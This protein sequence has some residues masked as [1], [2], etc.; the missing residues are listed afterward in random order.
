MSAKTWTIADQI[1]FAGASGDYNPIHIDP[2]YARRALFG[3]VVVHGIHL[4]VWALDAYCA[5][6][7][8]TLRLSKLKVVFRKPL[9]IN[10]EAGLQVHEAAGRTKLSVC[11]QGTVLADIVIESSAAGPLDIAPAAFLGRYP[12]CAP[13]EAA[14][15]GAVLPGGEFEI[16]ADL[17]VA[18]RLFPHLSRAGTAEQ[19]AFLLSTTRLVGMRCPGLYSVYNELDV[20]FAFSAQQEASAH[21]DVVDFNDVFKLALIQVRSKVAS[22]AIKAFV[23][24]QYRACHP[25]KDL[26]RQITVGEFARQKALVVGGSRGLGALTAKILALGGADVSLT[27]AKSRQDAEDLRQEMAAEGCRINIAE[28]DVLD[29]EKSLKD[30]LPADW[31]PTHL[32]YFAT[33]FVFEGTKKH[34]SAELFERFC[35]YYVSGFWRISVAALSIKT[36]TCIVY[37]SSSALDTLPP[38]MLEYVAAKQAGEAM[39]L[40]IEK[41][42]PGVKVLS[43]RLERLATD[44]TVS[45]FPVENKDPF[46]VLLNILRAT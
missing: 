13:V 21:Y 6:T 12:F 10:E 4:V 35:Q 19:T 1:D 45:L 2:V 5:Q 43:P 3:K 7:G 27:Y 31:R 42:F 23:R 39:G 18:A 33:P 9:G 20:D 34:F 26:R 29:R 24:P 36:L 41:N 25:A 46:P 37:P 15:G 40:Y 8:R 38:D 30:I 14:F 16:K 11:R 44:Q 17:D 28:L 22:A 32:Y